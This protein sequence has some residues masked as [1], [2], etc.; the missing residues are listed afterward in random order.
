MRGNEPKIDLPSMDGRGA[1]YPVSIKGVIFIDGRVV[2]LKNE[3][4]EWEL[5]GGR[6]EPGEIPAECVAREILEE[7]GIRVEVAAILDSWL[8]DIRGEIEVL[9]VTYGCRAQDVDLVISYEHKAVGLFQVGELS[10][11]NMPEGYRSSVRA[12]AKL[13]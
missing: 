2:L 1:R 13:V 7:L 9:I 11:L 10:A 6:L 12:W 8:Y 3:R 4:D 5:P